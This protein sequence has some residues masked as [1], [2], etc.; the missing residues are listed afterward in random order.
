MKHKTPEALAKTL[1]AAINKATM[2][3]CF[4][5]P[6][7][8]HTPRQREAWGEYLAAREAKEPGWL[9]GRTHG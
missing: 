2:Y 5:R 4:S 3:G 7:K 9:K 6:P 1:E 8:R